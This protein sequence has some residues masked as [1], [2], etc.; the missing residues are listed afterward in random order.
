MNFDLGTAAL[1]KALTPRTYTLRCKILEIG[2]FFERP[3]R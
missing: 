2:D 1:R 3:T